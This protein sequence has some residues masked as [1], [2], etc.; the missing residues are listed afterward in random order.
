[1]YSFKSHEEHLYEMMMYLRNKHG[2]GLMENIDRN[3][4]VISLTKLLQDF[5]S[6]TYFLVNTYIFSSIFY[7][8]KPVGY[9]R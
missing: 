4:L 7:L 2:N 9:H 8:Q 1:M 3:N 6:N 5:V